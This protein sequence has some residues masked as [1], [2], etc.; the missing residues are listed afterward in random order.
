MLIKYKVFRVCGVVKWPQVSLHVCSSACLLRVMTNFSFS[1]DSVHLL[2]T[3]HVCSSAGSLWARKSLSFH[4]RIFNLSMTILHFVLL[5]S[6]HVSQLHSWLP[7]QLYLTLLVFF[8]LI[9][10]DIWNL[11]SVYWENGRMTAMFTIRKQAVCREIQYKA[12]PY[13]CFNVWC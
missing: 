8:L 1:L 10:L 6:F 12:I 11:V 2:T 4:Q 3:F 13:H 7:L 5:R 9:V